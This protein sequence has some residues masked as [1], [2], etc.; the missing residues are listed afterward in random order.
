MKPGIYPGLPMAEYLGLPAMSASVLRET[1]DRCPAA[2]WFTSWLNPARARDDTAATDAGSIAHEILLEGSES[3]CDVI[4]P[5]EHPTEKTG[6]IPTGWTNKSIRR[7]RDD[8]RAAGKIPVL[9]ADMARIRSMVEAARSFIDTLRDTEPRIWD[10]FQPAGGASEVTL[11][12]QEGET[13]ARMRPDRLSNDAKLIVDAKITGRS[14]EPGAWGRSQLFGL[15]YHVSA[16][17]Y[18]R[19][20]RAL[21][22]VDCD[23]VF[24][25]IEDEPPYLCSLV[26]VD[27]AWLSLGDSVITIGLRIWEKCARD[28]HW[29]AYPSRVCYPEL[30]AWA[31]AAWNERQASDGFGIPYDI[32]KLFERKKEAA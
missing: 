24:L 25:V 7:A 16:S 20:V 12:W 15:G 28:G 27:P 23:Y 11:V 21:C 32:D 26:G 31:D 8:A 19:G 14:A 3:C 30:P 13:L 22:D 1:V 5:N 29:P 17:W 6:A 4:D 9:L 10:A 2:G 18:R